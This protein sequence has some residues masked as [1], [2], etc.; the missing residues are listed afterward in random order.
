V[1]RGE[2]PEAAITI[3][4]PGVHLGVPSIR[5][6]FFADTHLGFD[7]PQRPRV[8]RRR[9]GH[10]FFANFERVLQFA[11]DSAVDFVVHGGDL[12]FRS[13]V[14]AQLVQ[15]AFLPLKRVADAGIPVFLV[16]G[17]HE[18]SHI[19]YPMLALHPGIRIFD[20]P[21][22]FLEDV[23]DVRV[24]FA[25]FPYYKGDVRTGFRG[26]V[27]Q[28]GWHSARATV[29]LLCI[30]HCFEG[31]TVGPADYVFRHA[32]DVIRLAE[33]PPDFA[34]VLSGHIHRHQ[35]LVRDLKGQAIPTPILYPGSIE[36]TSFAEQNESKGYLLLEFEWVEGRRGW[37][38]RWEFH[39]LP[40]RP[41]LAHD[42]RLDG[43][44]AGELEAAIRRLV[45]QTPQDAILR[46]R[47]LGRLGREHRPVT[48]AASLRAMAPD[49]MNLEAVLVDRR[50]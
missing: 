34:A 9:R 11:V 23:G 35:V 3:T 29:N 19:P 25:G 50:W 17:N 38:S 42:L 15:R 48:R 32:S 41:M 7:L 14:P 40:A 20:R 16:P 33:V 49:T 26:L 36:R 8:I 1:G 45:G 12:F 2:P 22:T 13:R 10:D 28:T 44:T 47:L 37:L 46:I 43:R 6:L 18:R 4:G 30:H 27:E 31:A 39:E 21:R 5:I 24:A